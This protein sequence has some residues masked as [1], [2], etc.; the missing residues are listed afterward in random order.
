MPR[1][2][3]YHDTVV[4]A[5]TD[6]GW[7]VTDDPLRISYGLRN[8]YVD[9]G[10][11]R[12]LGAEKKERKIAVEIKSFTGESDVQE[13]AEAAGKCSMYRN[14]LNETDPGRVL[15]LAVP[16]YAYDGIFREPLGQ[17]MINRERFEIIVFDEI[18]ERVREWIP[19]NVTGK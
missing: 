9:L 18:R 7:T 10:A 19:Q 6:D 3:T 14:L 11:E 13:L 2:D 4:K 15:W 1:K 17:L 16:S 5:L 8:V 12:L